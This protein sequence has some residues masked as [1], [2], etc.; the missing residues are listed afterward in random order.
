V[1]R[2]CLVKLQPTMSRVRQRD[3]ARLRLCPLEADDGAWA[4]AHGVGVP[5]GA[6]V[7][8]WWLITAIAASFGAPYCDVLQSVIRLKRSAPAEK[9]NSWAAA[10]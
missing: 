6:P 10:S 9:V 5:L 4:L 7:L 1:G 3:R 8:V 2:P